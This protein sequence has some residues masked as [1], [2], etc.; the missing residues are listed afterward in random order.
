MSFRKSCDSI[1]LVRVCFILLLLFNFPSLFRNC[2]ATLTLGSVH[3]LPFY[4]FSFLF[5]P[6]LGPCLASDNEVWQGRLPGADVRSE[7]TLGLFFA[8]SHPFSSSFSL[9][10]PSRSSS[11]P[12][13]K[14]NKP[15]AP[16]GSKHISHISQKFNTELF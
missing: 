2:E 15:V 8:V 14:I 4:V 10:T 6:G 12:L 9:L 16:K 11:P 5:R 13:P 3:C 7:Q 1:T